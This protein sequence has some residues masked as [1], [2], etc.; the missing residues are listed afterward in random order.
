MLQTLLAGIG[1]GAGV[2]GLF[3][4]LFVWARDG[5]RFGRVVVPMKFDQTSDTG[6]RVVVTT[7]IEPRRA[8]TMLTMIRDVVQSRR[9]LPDPYGKI[10]DDPATGGHNRYSE[11]ERVEVGKRLRVQAEEH[12]HTVVQEIEKVQ[13]AL[14]APEITEAGESEPF[15]ESRPEE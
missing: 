13:H 2:T 15:P 10:V 4:V 5:R 3:V 11:T 7:Q 9:P 14:L 6:D 12:G 8:F 1:V